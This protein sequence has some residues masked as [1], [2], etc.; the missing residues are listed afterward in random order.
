MCDDGLHHKL[1]AQHHDKAS[2]EEIQR[3][4]AMGDKAELLS[5]KLHLDGTITG[6]MKPRDVWAMQPEFVDVKHENF[7]TD[8]ATVKR[9]IWKQRHHADVDEAG[10]LDDIAT[11][12]LAS[13]SD[14]C[15]D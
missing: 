15:W 5:L 4:N 8:F 3:E 11:H 7:C 13:S 12:L 14:G 2:K 1:N 10:C 9:T 6:A